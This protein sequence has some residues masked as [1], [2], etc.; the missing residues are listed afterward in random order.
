M[1]QNE[2]KAAEKINQRTCTSVV[3]IIIGV[4][5][6]QDVFIVKVKN[7]DFATNRPT[8]FQHHICHVYETAINDLSYVVAAIVHG[9]VEVRCGALLWRVEPC[10]GTSTAVVLTSVKW[11]NLL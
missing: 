6:V 4:S 2:M 5:A 8:I 11:N 1:C 9:P 7:A 3:G 10:T